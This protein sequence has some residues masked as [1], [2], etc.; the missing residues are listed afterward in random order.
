MT[1]A[2]AGGLWLVLAWAGAAG[3]QELTRDEERL[4][5][6]RDRERLHR[7]AL[8]VEG[9]SEAPD[10]FRAATPLLLASDRR[11]VEVD[12]RSGYERRLAMYDDPTPFRRPVARSQAP[13]LEAAV[14]DP[15]RP[16]PTSSGA[17]DAGGWVW[18]G[19]LVAFGGLMGGWILRRL[20]IL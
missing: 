20:G 6:E 11:R 13:R 15:R 1:R 10:G 2:V 17:G 7:G 12:L 8:E 18:I 14:E 9:L 3:A 19:S 5:R 16:E 4:L